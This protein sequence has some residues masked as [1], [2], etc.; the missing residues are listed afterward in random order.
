MYYAHG[1]YSYCRT[2]FIVYH[3]LPTL[4]IFFAYRSIECP[5]YVVNLHPRDVTRHVSRRS[6]LPDNS[7]CARS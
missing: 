4:P 3:S 1:H 5:E 2:V 6:Q 7:K